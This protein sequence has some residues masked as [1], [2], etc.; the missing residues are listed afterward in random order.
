MLNLSGTKKTLNLLSRQSR[1]R[2]KNGFLVRRETYWPVR[3]G[4]VELFRYLDDGYI[5]KLQKCNEECRD[6][7]IECVCDTA[8]VQQ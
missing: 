5:R 1:S 3:P 8:L 4:Y 6:E 2:P 7:Y